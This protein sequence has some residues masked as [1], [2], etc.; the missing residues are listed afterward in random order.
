MSG[1]GEDEATI[2]ARRQ[3]RVRPSR[4]QSCGEAVLKTVFPVAPPAAGVAELL[5]GPWRPPAAVNRMRR[6]AT[7]RTS[8]FTEAGR[9]VS[10]IAAAEQIAQLFVG[11]RRN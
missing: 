1:A 10:G 7:A 3:L 8:L 4:A 11:L 2:D 6:V 9:P 5:V